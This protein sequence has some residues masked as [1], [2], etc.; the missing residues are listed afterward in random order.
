MQVS[1]S[2]TL[3]TPALTAE[4]VAAFHALVQQFRYEEA[5]DQFYHEDL[6]KHENESAP[7][8]GLVAHR[9]EM[10]QFLSSIRNA[11]AELRQVIVSDDMSVAE[12]YYTFE[13]AQWGAR[14]FAQVSVQRWR[15]GR[16]YH[17]RHHYRMG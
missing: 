7:T 3:S 5:H 15:D 14:A 13:H 2:S 8:I 12:W 16:I 6:V 9:A 11:N 10:R 1:M 4:H 17:E